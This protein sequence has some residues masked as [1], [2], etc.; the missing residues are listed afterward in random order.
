MLED[1]SKKK[2]HLKEENYQEDLWQ[3]NCL[4]S[5]I[6]SMTKNIGE[7]QREIEDNGKEN[8]EMREKY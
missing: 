1:K 7:D 4:G 6:N 2:E 3:R 5:Q 8:K